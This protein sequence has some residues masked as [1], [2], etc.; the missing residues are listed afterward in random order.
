MQLMIIPNTTYSDNTSFTGIFFRIVTGDNDSTITWPFQLKTVL[1]IVHHNESVPFVVTPNTDPCRL[2]SA[3][4]RPSSDNDNNPHP[5][6]CGN[7]RHI[8]LDTLRQTYLSN[9]QSLTINAMIYLNDFGSSYKQA[10]MGMKYNN[11]I[12]NFEWIIKDFI[13]IQNESLTNENVVVLTSEPFYTHSS[14]YLMQMFMTV[15]PKKKAFALSI[16]LS[17]GDHDRLE[18]NIRI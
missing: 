1:S 14:G 11:L 9:E 4:L 17:Q 15:L 18:S 13:K 5:D 8:Q 2:R 6:G 16:A 10:K 12:S 7:R 3:F